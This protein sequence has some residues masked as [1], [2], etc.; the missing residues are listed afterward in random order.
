MKSFDDFYAGLVAE[1][2]AEG[3]E[4]IAELRAF[5]HHFAEAARTAVPTNDDPLSD[6]SQ[7]GSKAA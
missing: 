5:E 4:A 7:H 1:A 3:P 2:E 6:R